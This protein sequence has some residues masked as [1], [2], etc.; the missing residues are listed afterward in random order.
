MRGTGAAA[1]RRG[2][3]RPRGDGAGGSSRDGLGH[4]WWHGPGAL[5][6]AYLSFDAFREARTSHLPELGASGASIRH[7]LGHGVV[8]NA[9]SPH[10]WVCWVLIGGPT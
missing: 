5:F 3:H 1:D 10:P 7:A 8:V 2:H 9:L 4:R 6:A